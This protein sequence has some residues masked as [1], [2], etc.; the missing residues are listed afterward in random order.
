MS[1]SMNFTIDADQERRVIFSK[2]YG[3][4]K[5]ETAHEYHD[6]FMKVVQPLLTEKWVKLINLLNW[7]TSYPEM[8]AVIGEH[9]NWCHTH[10]AVYSIYV[11]DNPITRNQLKRMIA[12]SDYPEECK[13]FASVSEADR[14]LKEKGF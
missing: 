13:I 6:E 4:W 12:H 5:E 9:I 10:N 2:I 8:V 14:F 1:F 7:K 11:V 3:I